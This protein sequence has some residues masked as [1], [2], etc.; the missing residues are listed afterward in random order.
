MRETELHGEIRDKFIIQSE[1]G[2]A[3]I[4]SAAE[5]FKSYIFNS[6]ED[7]EAFLQEYPEYMEKVED[8]SIK[9]FVVAFY[10]RAILVEFA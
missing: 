9:H 5:G 6:K 8:V 4:R 7:A 1:L 10:D 3:G 2:N